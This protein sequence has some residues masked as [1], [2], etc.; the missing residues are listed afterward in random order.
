MLLVTAGA[1][2]APAAAEG[3]LF[4]PRDDW[5]VRASSSTEAGPRVTLGL[6]ALEADDGRWGVDLSGEA[7]RSLDATPAWAGNARTRW[8]ATVEGWHAVGPA[9]VF[10]GTG[11][12]GASR[13]GFGE[14]PGSQ[15]HAGIEFALEGAG[16]LSLETSWSMPG[17]GFGVEREHRVAW[18]RALA[19]GWRA[20]LEASVVNAPGWS[21]RALLATVR[22]RF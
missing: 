5:R 10:A 7:R 3:G 17:D 1:F 22:G 2:A 18:N 11:I 4:V 9:V 16:A 12:S 15:A 13:E 14:R 8:S 21:G 19:R 6:R 20:G